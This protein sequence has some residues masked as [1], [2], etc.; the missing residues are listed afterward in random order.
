MASVDDVIV[1]DDDDDEM[2]IPLKSDWELPKQTWNGEEGSQSKTSSLKADNCK[3]FDQFVDYC[4]SFTQ[5]HPEVITFLKNRLSKVNPT[6]LSSVE[7]HNILGRCLTRVQSKHSKVYVYINELCTAFKANS[8]KRKVVLKTTVH[9]KS[10]SRSVDGI[11]NVEV[12]EKP[13]EDTTKKNGNKRQIRY[14][15]NLLRMYSREIQKL[16]EKELTLEEMEDEDSSYI[17][18]ARLKRKLIRIFQKLCDLKDCPSLTGRVIEQRIIYNG[19]R[20]PEVNRRLEKFVNQTHDCFPDY[21]DVLRVI[22]RASQKHN[23]GLVPKQMEGMA[24]DAFRELGNRL[25]ERRHLDLVYNFGCHLTDTYKAGVDPAFQD[26]SLTRRLRENR[27]VALSQ[28]EGVIKKYADMQDDGEDEEW[29]NKKTEMETPNSIKGEQIRKRKGSSPSSQESDESEEV[30]S[31]T[32]IEDELKRCEA[33]SDREEGDTDEEPLPADRENEVD[34]LMEQICDP[35]PSTSTEGLKIGVVE[36]K[37]INEDAEDKNEDADVKEDFELNEAAEERPL[38]EDVIQEMSLGQASTPSPPSPVRSPVVAEPKEDSPPLDNSISFDQSLSSNEIQEC[39][40]HIESPQKDDLLDK[41]PSHLES[42][43]TASPSMEIQTRVDEENS[44]ERDTSS[45]DSPS[46]SDAPSNCSSRKIHHLATHGKP[47][48]LVKESN[49]E[50]ASPTNNS[51]PCV[52][53]LGLSITV[54]NTEMPCIEEDKEECPVEEN[55]EEQPNIVESLAIC[56]LLHDMENN[57][58][59]DEK[60][61][62]LSPNMKG[63]RHVIK[64]EDGLAEVKEPKEKPQSHERGQEKELC[65]VPGASSLGGRNGVASINWQ[66]ATKCLQSNE[67][68]ILQGC[69]DH[70]RSGKTTGHNLTNKR[71]RSFPQAFPENGNSPLN[72]NSKDCV[73]MKNFKRPRK[74]R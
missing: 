23:L 64:I 1:L 45:E 4:S 30:D 32:D 34:Q 5:E 48:I 12:K 36:E 8:S 39:S 62:L 54:D 38:R 51:T 50:S 11:N 66:E 67:I 37:Q 19:T 35:Q 26:Q 73:W 16:Q 59:I 61:E 55:G 27:T 6:F 40:D 70:N 3:L 22:Q 56:N 21:G 24:Q 63:A 65:K 71:K 52:A 2:P 58:D 49:E 69:S 41:S 42:N 33:M 46:P 60:V 15:E 9:Q 72:G 18:E 17:Q 25:Q 20:F 28:L 53:D 44:E 57:V 7:F 10:P 29:R 68:R 43:A 74:N 14:L 31:E 13:E 47:Q